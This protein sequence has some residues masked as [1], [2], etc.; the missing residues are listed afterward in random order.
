MDVAEEDALRVSGIAPE[1]VEWSGVVWAR[2]TE[3]RQDQTSPPS[4]SNPNALVF[5]Q[6]VPNEALGPA[7]N[8][9]R[10]SFYK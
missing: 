1:D 6:F 3:A 4:A 2:K 5:L 7:I 10:K 9:L 8:L